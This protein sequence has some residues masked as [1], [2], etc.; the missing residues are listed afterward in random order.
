MEH[1]KMYKSG[2]LWVTAVIMSV[3]LG[4]ATQ[5]D[6]KADTVTAQQEQRVQ[7]QGEY[8]YPSKDGKAPWMQNGWYGDDDSASASSHVVVSPAVKVDPIKE[9]Q[10]MVDYAQMHVDMSQKDV[11]EAQNNVDKITAQLKEA[12]PEK[13]QE[14]QAA[15]SQLQK[16]IDKLQAKR[17]DM[18]AQQDRNEAIEEDYYT[19][20]DNYEAACDEQIK[21]NRALDKANSIYYNATTPDEKEKAFTDFVNL[22]KAFITA[23]EKRS[24]AES[25]V[26]EKA[27]AFEEAFK[28]WG[29]LYDKLNNANEELRTK[30]I[31]LEQL[32]KKFDIQGLHEELADATKALESAKNSLRIDQEYLAKQQKELN[33]LKN[34]LNKNNQHEDKTPEISKKEPEHGS[35]NIGS[36]S[37]VEVDKV[38]KSNHDI[39]AQQP[40]LT[41]GENG[42]FV[43]VINNKTIDSK[44]LVSNKNNVN[45]E[46][47]MN[48]WDNVTLP[49]TGNEEEATVSVVGLLLAMFGIYGLRKKKSY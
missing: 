19:A 20:T 34:R 44:A 26:E 31:E 48:T 33:D 45:R 12:T 4:V 38:E 2:K 40:V 6:V 32:K 28:Q 14:N 22:Q 7:S 43:E 11:D 24:K 39:S 13:I 5:H 41:S 18:Q 16:E 1:K 17:D 25:I 47:D 42:D 29:I 46:A 15:V 27:P 10:G 30:K 23:S 8:Y 3:G 35:M 21:Y 9:Q 37:E 49:K 36:K